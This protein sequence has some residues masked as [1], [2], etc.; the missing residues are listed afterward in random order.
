[1]KKYPKILRFLGAFVRE[2]VWP[3][4]QMAGVT[5]ILIGALMIFNFMFCSG[6]GMILQFVFPK[7]FLPEFPP[8]M[9][10][11]FGLII[12]IIGGSLGYAVIMGPIQFYKWVRKCWRE[13]E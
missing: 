1:M 6:L 5:I 8:M 10:G 11:A 2:L 12:C 13:F 9:S 3:F 7:V 4:L